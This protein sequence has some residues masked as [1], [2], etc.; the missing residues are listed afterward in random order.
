M[1]PQAATLWPH[2]RWLLAVLLAGLGMLGPF[3]IDTYLPAFEGIARSTGA[4]P[5]QLQQTLSSYL[6]GFAVMNLFH[7]ALSDAIGRRPVV[8]AG[9]GVFTLASAGCALSSTIE[10]LIF[11]RA[12]Q[13]MCAGAGMVVS[14]AII[15]DL[16][17]PSEAQRVMS[18]VTIFFG[19]APAIAPLLG[20]YLYV[21]ADWHAIFWF[22]TGVG[23]VLLAVNIKALPESLPPA[24]KQHFAVRPLMQGYAS[25]VKSPRFLL[26]VM[27]SG[28]PFNSM[29]LYVL[30]APEYL[31]RHLG[32]GPTQFFWF[33]L[34]TIGGIMGGAA[35]SGRVAGK[36]K[37]ES[38]IR[39]GFTLM[40]VGVLAN[41]LLVSVAPHWARWS[42]PLIALFS[43]GWAFM[44][45][46]VTIMVLD[47]N[48]ERRGM[49][50][51]LQSALSAAANA[52]VAGALVPLVMH[53]LQA[54]A[55]TAVGFLMVGLV[56]WQWV[57]RFP[58][59]MA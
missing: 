54:L 27:A 52:L 48:P 3:S 39:R 55:L 20:G 33:F 49:A 11:W 8:L 28:I 25:L 19:V 37:P 59:P 42:L 30:A 10:G 24:S 12:V 14:R 50:S 58:R 40:L 45:P 32:L 23:A 2:P 9:L 51:S 53:S 44:V 29:F 56:A 15:R 16:F 18:Q 47:E 22:L 26:L 6:M 21:H 46:V 17:P 5:V 1:H 36:M 13:G 41:L 35:W 57:R 7:G 43:L 31:G 4:T 38:Q 34:C